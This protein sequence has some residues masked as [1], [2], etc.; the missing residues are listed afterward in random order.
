MQDLDIVMGINEIFYYTYNQDISIM[1]KVINLFSRS[2][3]VK[4][5]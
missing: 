3:I 5:I 2:R 1:R 4:K